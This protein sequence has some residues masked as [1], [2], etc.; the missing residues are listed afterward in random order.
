MKCLGMYWKTA[1]CSLGTSQ[2][3]REKWLLA[4]A[5]SYEIHSE[6]RLWAG[7]RQEPPSLFPNQE[8]DASDGLL[9]KR[10]ATRYLS[11]RMTSQ[12]QLEKSEG[13]N[14]GTQFANALLA[15]QMII[16]LL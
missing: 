1:C 7:V 13:Q 5:P 15:S 4:Q 11:L 10:R 6:V 14:Q 3:T 9:E 2:S 8:G 16:M 12:H